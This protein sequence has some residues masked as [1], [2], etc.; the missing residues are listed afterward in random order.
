MFKSKITPIIAVTALVVAVFGATPLGQAA[1][2]LVLPKNS[3]GAVQIKKNAVANKKIAKNAI[4]SPKVKDGTL[5]AAD[6]K[7]GQL[8]AGPAGPKGD[9]GP[10]GDQGI[11]GIQGIQ[12]QKGAKG[13]PG[14][15]NVRV[16]DGASGPQAGPGGVSSTTASCQPGETLVGG[17]AFADLWGLPKPTVVQERP[18]NNNTAWYVVYRNDGPAGTLVSARALAFCASP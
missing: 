15:T 12:G 5:M 4:T 2:R 10:K 14:A 3:V 13:D 1:S 16:R 18:V 6:F 11:Q 9:P 8:P 7:G 17:G